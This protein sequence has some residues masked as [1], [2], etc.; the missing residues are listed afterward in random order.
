MTV[1]DRNSSSCKIHAKIKIGSPVTLIE[2]D[3]EFKGKVV[4]IGNF[5]NAKTQSV[6][7]M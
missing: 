7:S 1:R 2:D 4:R 3:I 5:I 6:P